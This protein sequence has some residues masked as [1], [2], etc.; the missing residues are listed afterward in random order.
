MEDDVGF[1]SFV[2]ICFIA[3]FMFLDLQRCR[4]K[5]GYDGLYRMDP[6][7]SANPSPNNIYVPLT[8]LQQAEN[9]FSA[10]DGPYML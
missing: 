10:S 3:V 6:T 2:I 5:E 9:N 8:A 7:D 1:W 4:H